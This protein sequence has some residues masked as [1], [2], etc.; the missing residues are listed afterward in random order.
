[1]N[2]PTSAYS[3]VIVPSRLIAT[4]FAEYLLR[5]TITANSSHIK[6]SQTG[7]VP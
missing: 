3:R 6:S 5:S 7:S 4:L 1:M 2:R